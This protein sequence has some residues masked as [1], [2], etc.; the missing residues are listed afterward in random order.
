MER[1]LK[2]PRVNLETKWVSR[3]CKNRI[4]IIFQFLSIL[5]FTNV[6][7]QKEHVPERYTICLEVTAVYIIFTTVFLSNSS[8]HVIT[9][10][11]FV[12][13]HAT[14][15]IIHKLKKSQTNEQP[16]SLLSQ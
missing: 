8:I 14:L 13:Y 6:V 16:L 5:D 9:R 1:N 2:I 11:C 4:Q 7:I 10:Y 3:A 15:V 12:G